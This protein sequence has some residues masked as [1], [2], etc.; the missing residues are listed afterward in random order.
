MYFTIFTWQHWISEQGWQSC[1]LASMTLKFCSCSMLYAR[2]NFGIT[3]AEFQSPSEPANFIIC[4]LDQ[5]WMSSHPCINICT[6]IYSP[7]SHCVDCLTVDIFHSD[8]S[9]SFAS[10]CDYDEEKKNRNTRIAYK[11][12]WWKNSSSPIAINLHFAR[13]LDQTVYEHRKSGKRHQSH[14]RQSPYII[15]L[16]CRVGGRLSRN[17]IVEFHFLVHIASAEEDFTSDVMSFPLEIPTEVRVPPSTTY[18]IQLD[19]HLRSTDW[20][21]LKIYFAQQT[22]PLQ[23]HHHLSDAWRRWHEWHGKKRIHVNRIAIW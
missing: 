19:L 1:M 2:R 17:S 11:F 3:D 21:F 9:S 6:G 18:R 8:S 14:W 15:V 20:I 12:K 10:N 23:N 5:S 16:L 13:M 7:F 4:L 22:I